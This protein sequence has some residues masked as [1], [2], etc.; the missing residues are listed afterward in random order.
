MTKAID[1]DCSEFYHNRQFIVFQEH[2]GVSDGLAVDGADHLW[3]TFWFGG[4]LVSIVNSSLKLFACSSAVS[5]EGEKVLA[6]WYVD[7]LPGSQQGYIFEID[8]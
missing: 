6:P 4:K 8:I 3:V 7:D 2:E 1:G 5:W